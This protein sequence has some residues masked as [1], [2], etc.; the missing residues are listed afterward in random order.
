MAKTKWAR[1]V[2]HE[3]LGADI[4]RIHCIADDD[5]HH[6][7]GNYVILRSTLTNPEKPEDVLKRAYS[8][9][10]AP[11]ASS[12]R[13]F[14]FTVINTGATSEWLSE[15]R[16][17]DRLEFSGPWGKKFRA[18]PDDPDTVVHLFATG[19]GFSPI[20]AM[21]VSRTQNGQSPVHLWWQTSHKYD[22][23]VLET[24]QSNNR[25]KVSVG[26]NLVDL[27]PADPKALYFFAGD[28][29]TIVPLCNRLISE[30]VPP[31]QLRTEYFFN[32]PP[33]S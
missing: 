2:G 16:E 28:G 10:S 27:V 11:N 32:K 6:V 5:F 14:H 7:A 4:H 26:N 9:S 1:V 8:I 13:D 30:G 17:G 33:K 31:Q 25:F 23:E 29:E 19:T 18:Q 12:P 3:H 15:R 24:L 21:A 20:G 22:E